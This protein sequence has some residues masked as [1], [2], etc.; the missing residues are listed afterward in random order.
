M[1]QTKKNFLQFQEQNT[2]ILKTVQITCDAW[3]FRIE[4]AAWRD[5]AG[6]PLAAKPIISLGSCSA[7]EPYDPNLPTCSAWRR[8][9]GTSCNSAFYWI[10]P[11][12]FGTK[13]HIEIFSWHFV[14]QTLPPPPQRTHNP[15][16]HPS[17]TSLSYI[18]II[19]WWYLEQSISDDKRQI[20]IHIHFNVRIVDRFSKIWHR[21]RLHWTLPHSCNILWEATWQV[22]ARLR[23]CQP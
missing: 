21:R 10:A 12:I 9:Y 22:A 2:V 18:I 6:E 14:S 3:A 19:D 1:P 20:G 17:S 5:M 4:P 16:H 15:S 11:R 13:P 7:R 8:R 23:R